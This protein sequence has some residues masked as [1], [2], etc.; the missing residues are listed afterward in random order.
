MAQGSHIATSSPPSHQARSMHDARITAL[1]S[2]LARATERAH[3]A[4]AALACAGAEAE[5][6]RARVSSLEGALAAA[7]S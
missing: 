3:T 2:D 4:E 1:S 7:A 5:R 6:Y